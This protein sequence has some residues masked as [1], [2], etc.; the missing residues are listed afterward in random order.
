MD[1]KLFILFIL[2]FTIPL[3][4]STGQSGLTFL[5]LPTSARTG[6]V[7]DVFS[8]STSSP[9][10]I[11]KSPL[12]IGSDHSR[13]AFSHNIWFADVRSEVLALSFP[14]SYGNFALGGNLVRIP[15]IEV[16]TKP[17]DKPLQNIEAQYFSG[18]L[19]YNKEILKSIKVG[20]TFKYLYEYGYNQS[21]NGF[22]TDLGII[23][24]SPADL[25][26]SLQLNNLG[27]MQQLDETSTKLPRT[28]VV[29]IMRPEIF[30]EGPVSA[31]VG[32]NLK[33]NLEDEETGAQFGA[34]AIL[35]N[36]FFLR[37]GYEHFGQVSKKSFGIG[38]SYKKFMVD[39]AFIIMDNGL[40]NPKL[41]SLC[42]RF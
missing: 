17:S 38:L 36:T 11:F 20:A 37:G 23:W 13:I 41:I 8:S 42:Y 9:A 31:A 32:I 22:G 33:S 10:T 3:F 29:G 34:E 14:T 18:N 5:T 40:S 1:R 24:N 12:G 6:A 4:C 27:K 16:R 25:N 15:G 28:V 39:Y 7:M 19:T 35:F 2:I 30:N 26:V 21:A